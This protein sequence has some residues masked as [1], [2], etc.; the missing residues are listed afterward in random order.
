MKTGRDA[1]R[2]GLYISE[3]CL[4]EVVLS[5]GQM[6]P[7][8]PRCYALTV[9]QFVKQLAREQTEQ[10]LLFATD[11]TGVRAR[12]RGFHTGTIAFIDDE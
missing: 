1:N 6:C 7:R 12:A 11:G 10:T 3:C 5:K 8:C 9:W 2:A 4:K